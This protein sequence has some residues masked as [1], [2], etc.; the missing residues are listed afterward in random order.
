MFQ[1]AANTI[2][3]LS[4]DMIEKANSGHPGL[5]M[6]MADCATVL[7]TQFLRFN[8][9]DP[10]W[11]GRDRFILSGGHGSA[12]LYSMLH[13]SGYDYSIEDLKQF[14][15]WG[16][17]TPGHP[18]VQLDG[19]ET[20]T[21]PLG[22]GLGNAVGM[23]LA[24]KMTAAR[25][26]SADKLFS[27]QQ[28]YVFCG[29]GD[30]MEGLSSEVSS[31][32]GHWKLGNLVC[33][34]DSNRITIDGSTDLAFTEDVKG[35]YEAYGWK[36]LEI[37]GHDHDEIENALNIA[38][39]T[40][41]APV[42]IIA[43]TRIGCGSPNKQD[44]AAAHGAPLGQDEL[45][46]TKK[47]LGLDPEKS[48]QVPEEVKDLFQK[49]RDELKKE[50]I[51]WQNDY[52]QWRKNS[53]EDEKHYSKF[54]L[55][56]I[57]PELETAI[58]SA[59]SGKT[60]ATRSLSCNFI[61]V[62]AKNL[63]GLVGGS[64]DLAASNKTLIKD[65]GILSREN[66]AA[67]NIFYGIREFAMGT[68]MNGISLYGGFVPFG[69]TFL[70]FSD[71]MRSAI[72]MAALMK[73]QVIY[74]YTHDS[75]FVGED[76]PTHQPIEHLAS[77]KMIPGL[78]V[79]RPADEEE[80]A[81]AWA[82]AVQRTDGPTALVLSRQKLAFLKKEE[83]FSNQDVVRG[84]Y[85][86]ETEKT[87]KIDIVLAASGSEVEPIQL[88]AERLTK[89]G[90]SARVVSVPSLTRFMQQTDEYKE[91]VFPK[92]ACRTIVVE[93]AHP[94]GWGDVIRTPYRIIAMENFGKSAPYQVLAKKFGFNADTVYEAAIG[95]LQEK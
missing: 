94:C 21:G 19:V 88:A 73:I 84:A 14:R 29:D 87:E 4:A 3:C 2:R 64:A 32:A 24:N 15:Q 6:G 37:D 48:F 62:I 72:R 58:L 55:K 26:P 67:K 46:L 91:T 38:K 54:I 7:W 81:A 41:D 18:E 5:P 1:L 76:G 69:G 78:D 22:Q 12:L 43:K 39:H 61:Q 80:T 11:A 60:D 35:R 83:Q 56:E 63:D 10:Q 66:F 40:P 44:T 16:S 42:L 49:R 36:V 47:A 31:L 30:M 90:Y 77:L 52:A 82:Y 25:Y 86:L 57:A 92:D 8:P 65:G 85:I 75:I 59:V 70:V 23:A 28:I 79:I 9:L 45:K 74:V 17:K 95:W 68:I 33:M 53:P 50:Y 89:D 71:Y 13:L 27:D 51:K 93:A 20:T 34:Y